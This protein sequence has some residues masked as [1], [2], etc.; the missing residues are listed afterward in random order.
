MVNF[1]SILNQK[2]S[3]QWGGASS[4]SRTQLS[5]FTSTPAG[6]TQTPQRKDKGSDSTF[7]I[8]AEWRG[9]P[10]KNYK[11]K[12][13]TR[14]ILGRFPCFLMKCCAKESAVLPAALVDFHSPSWHTMCAGLTQV[15]VSHQCE[16]EPS[17]QGKPSQSKN[18]H[19]NVSW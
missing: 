6:L 19:V 5:I 18:K 10:L 7:E 17:F 16:D 3:F 12:G 8:N 15:N 1:Y 4:F 9:K 13:T 14:H 2:T 11:C